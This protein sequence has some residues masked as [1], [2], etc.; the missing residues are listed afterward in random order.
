M[1]YAVGEFVEFI[2]NSNQRKRRFGR[3]K[4]IVSLLLSQDSDYPQDTLKMLR[5]L[6]HDELAFIVVMIEVIADTRS[7]E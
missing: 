6:K 7:F 5:L 2:N 3:I 4:A 1:E